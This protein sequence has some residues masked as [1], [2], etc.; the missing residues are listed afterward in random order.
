MAHF[1]RDAFE[2]AKSSGIV[3]RELD[4]ED[5]A[6]ALV[7]Q[8]EGTLSLAP[9]SQQTATLDSG[10]RSLRRQVESMRSPGGER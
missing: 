4:C 6:H 5:A 10:A 2:R 3:A 7:A 1:Y 8:I 9:N